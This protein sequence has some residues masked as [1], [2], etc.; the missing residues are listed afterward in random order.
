[1]LVSF[2]SYIVA[3]LLRQR[4]RRLSQPWWQGLTLGMELG[5]AVMLARVSPHAPAAFLAASGTCTFVAPWWLAGVQ[6]HQISVAGPWDIA[7][8]PG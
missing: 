5:A 3:P 4:L 7:D 1:M 2:Q 6:R 8:V